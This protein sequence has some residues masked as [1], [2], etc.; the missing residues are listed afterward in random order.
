MSNDFYTTETG[1]GAFFLDHD[2]SFPETAISKCFILMVTAHGNRPGQKPNGV[3][4]QR[5]RL[6]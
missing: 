6:I 5:W 2:G 3:H 4:L 1:S